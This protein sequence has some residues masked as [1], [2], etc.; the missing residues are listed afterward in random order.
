MTLAGVLAGAKFIA[1]AKGLMTLLG[2]I[3]G[4]GLGVKVPKSL[5]FITKQVDKLGAV[6]V[7]VFPHVGKF[8]TSLA[9]VAPRLAS[10]LA[11]VPGWGTA[12]MALILLFK[13]LMSVLDSLWT[14][15]KVFFQLL[16]NFDEQTGLS[17]V[18]K[19]DAE[20]LGSFY[21]VI[22]TTAKWSLFLI[23]AFKGLAQGISEPI[24]QVI[25]VLGK[26]YSYVSDL[27]DGF[28]G[29][30]KTGPALSSWLTGTTNLFRLLGKAIGFV[31]SA[32]LFA[33]NPIASIAGMSVFGGSLVGDAM[34]ALGMKS[35]M[36]EIN[37]RSDSVS[38]PSP[39]P[40]TS[41]QISQPA[42]RA[43]NLDTTEN[44]SEILKNI[45]KKL[46]K[47]T[48]MMETDSQKQDIRESQSSARNNIM[49]RR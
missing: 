39:Q 6:V 11:F 31:A 23:A 4:A 25:S 19:K 3:G 27:T 9:F 2:F 15:T 45:D 37:S 17:K 38:Q 28:W 42:P 32:A 12:I 18:L 13:P 7:R 47:Q 41:T 44:W 16:S 36:V 49:T 43:M 34:D 21:N 40:Q 48:D 26:A 33:I 5:M 1:G 46:G 35:K 8:L 20:A 22:E 10:A 14:S 24:S 29:F 30:A